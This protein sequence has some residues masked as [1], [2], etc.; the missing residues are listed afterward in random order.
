MH[1]PDTNSSIPSRP[2]TLSLRL[3]KSLH[4]FPTVPLAIQNQSLLC[5]FPT[6]V[7]P[8]SPVSLLCHTSVTCVTSVTPPSF[9]CHSSNTSQGIQQSIDRGSAREFDINLARRRDVKRVTRQTGQ[10]NEF[11]ARETQHQI[12]ITGS[13]PCNHPCTR[14]MVPDKSF[15]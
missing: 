6:Q 11:R 12:R 3:H 1:S 9:L 10:P 7:T 2:V 4:P 8:R 15:G 5:P 14:K 13:V